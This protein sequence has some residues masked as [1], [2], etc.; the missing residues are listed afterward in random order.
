MNPSKFSIF[1]LL[2]YAIM[3]FVGCFAACVVMN[4]LKD[5]EYDDEYDYNIVMSFFCTAMFIVFLNV[6]YK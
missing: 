1:K 3:Q 6:I 5:I 2:K 4:S